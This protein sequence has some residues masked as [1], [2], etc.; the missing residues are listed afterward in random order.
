ME[1]PLLVV[2]RCIYVLDW[3]Q[4]LKWPIHFTSFLTRSIFAHCF[5]LITIIKAVLFG[6]Q[7]TGLSCKELHTTHRHTTDKIFKKNNTIDK[8]NLS[9]IETISC[10]NFCFKSTRNQMCKFVYFH[11]VYLM[12]FCW[13]CHNC[14]TWLIIDNVDQG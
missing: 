9:R 4:L 2:Q 13:V 12:C 6:G 5:S 14:M 1:L 7:H 11:T 10:S 8:V 3:T